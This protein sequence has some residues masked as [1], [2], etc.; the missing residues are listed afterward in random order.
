[1]TLSGGVL[2]FCRAVDSIKIEKLDRYYWHMVSP[3]KLL[4]L[5]RCYKK[6]ESYVALT[7][8][9]REHIRLCRCNL[10]RDI[11]I[12]CCQPRPT[13]DTV[14]GF[15]PFCIAVVTV[16]Y[17]HKHFLLRHHVLSS[18]ANWWPCREEFYLSAGLWS[19]YSTALADG[20]SSLSCNHLVE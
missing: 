10:W 9:Q 6:Y 1:M 3:K 18:S 11:G 16:F 15:L 12:T 17:C 14:G 4:P 7:W 5:W 2:P 8:W 19:P 13:D 20:E